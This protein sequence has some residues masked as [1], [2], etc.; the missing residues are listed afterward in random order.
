MRS[1]PT[2]QHP[3]GLLSKPRTVPVSP[4][5]RGNCFAHLDLPSK[6][7]DERAVPGSVARNDMLTFSSD[8]QHLIADLEQTEEGAH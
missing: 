2:K 5:W 1:I 6:S 7:C 8:H 3:H 4:G